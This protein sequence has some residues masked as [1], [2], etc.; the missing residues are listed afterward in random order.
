VEMVDRI[1]CGFDYLGVSRCRGT[2]NTLRNPI[3]RDAP[4]GGDIH[5]GPFFGRFV[6][7]NFLVAFSDSLA[8]SRPL[9]RLSDGPPLFRLECRI[10]FL[11]MFS[12]GRS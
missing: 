3:G 12:A 9:R 6:L 11:Q 5:W 10:G 2:S 1:R 7:A 4:G 8:P